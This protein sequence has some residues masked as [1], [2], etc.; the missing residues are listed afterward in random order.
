[1]HPTS[2]ST[3]CPCCGRRP[4]ARAKIIRPAPLLDWIERQA[5]I[6]PVRASASPGARLMLRH[7][8]RDAAG[9][10]RACIALPGRLPLA[11]PSLSAALA[12]LPRMEADHGGR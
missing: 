1:M 3:R 5:A 12:A 4:R 6:A 8:L 10:P 9:E 11:F 7:D 2:G